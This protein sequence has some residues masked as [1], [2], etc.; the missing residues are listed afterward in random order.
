MLSS[1]P[2]DLTSPPKRIGL[3]IRVST[4]DQAA[5][6]SPKHHEMRGR[7]F[8]EARGWTVVELYNLA[9]V[10]GKAVMEHSETKRMMDDVVRGHID[11]LVFSKLARLTR[12]AREL[13]EF[14]DFFL[15]NGADMV[16]LQENIDTSSPAGRLFYNMVAVMAQWE[17]EEI[18]DRITSSVKVRAKLGKPINGKAPYGYQWVNKKLVV[19]PDEAPVRKLMYEL[20]V[21]HK[22]RKTVCRLLNE[23]GYRTRGGGGWTDTAL[24]HVLQDPS[25]KGQYRSN[26]TKGANNGKLRVLKPEHEWVYTP[27]EPLVSED[28]WNNCQEIIEGRRV[29]RDRR[30]GPKPVHLFTGLALCKCGKKMTVPGNTPKY[31]CPA[32]RR[33]I[34]I[35]DLEALFM[36]ELKN[37]LVSPQHIAAYLAGAN[38]TLTEKEGLLAAHQEEVEKANAEAERV[39]QLYMDRALTSEQFKER[40]QPFDTRKHQ[41]AEE[42]PR[43]QAE[44]D[45]LKMDGLNEREIVAEIQDLHAR[46]PKMPFDQKRNLVEHLVRSIVIGDGEIEFKVS[47]LPHF[48]QMSERQHKL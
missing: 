40:Y 43:L 45:L 9:G 33:K 7:Y 23:K 14:S 26:Y 28:L 6:D 4:E 25:A 21:Q 44:V 48:E 8:A 20:F 34:P 11:A 24:G 5:G 38:L 42:L 46:W 30:P 10:S 47:Y 15:K 13:M 32:C 29:H 17:R 1:L 19:H 41:L 27:V 31:V 18:V 37:Y 2:P 12:N 36:D 22:R 3:W 16:S 35:A 39:F